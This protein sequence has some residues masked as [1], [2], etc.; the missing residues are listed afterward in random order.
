[1]KTK[2]LV[3]SDTHGSNHTWLRL[4]KKYHF[5]YCLHAGDHL[6]PASF[7]NQY[8]SFWV[9]GN[10]DHVGEDLQTFNIRNKQ[11]VLLHGHQVAP[12]Y[13]FQPAMFVDYTKQFGPNV[14]IFGHTHQAF[15]KEIDHVLLL[16]PGSLTYPRNK[17]GIPTYAIVE[18]DDDGQITP[19]VNQLNS[20]L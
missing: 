16:N 18:I 11:F 5:D 20:Q 9:A 8:A 3:V 6:S 15:L 4:L 12:N 14:I 10:N 7:M 2:I 13:D 1:M 17:N 19:F